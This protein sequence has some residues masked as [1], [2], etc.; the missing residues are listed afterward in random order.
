LISK[1]LQSEV[2]KNPKFIKYVKEFLSAGV[3]DSPRNIFAKLGINLT[4][5]HFWERGLSEVDQLL[6]ETES[7]AKKLKKI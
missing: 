6:K 7:L 2:R 3:S 5:R 1:A 4:D